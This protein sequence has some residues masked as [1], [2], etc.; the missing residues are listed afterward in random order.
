MNNKRHVIKDSRKMMVPKTPFVAYSTV[1]S[2][3]LVNIIINREAYS[4]LYRGRP[5]AAPVDPKKKKRRGR[6]GEK[7][8][9]GRNKGIMHGDALAVGSDQRRHDY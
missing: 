2:C 8:S 3:R 5:H 6:K 7:C 9:V 1:S 4:Q